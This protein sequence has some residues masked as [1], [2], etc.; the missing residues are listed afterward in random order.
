M[1]GK[2]KALQDCKEKLA[3]DSKARNQAPTG[4][5]STPTRSSSTREKNVARD[6]SPLRIANVMT[7]A[8]MSMILLVFPLSVRES[9][10]DRFAGDR[11]TLTSARAGT[12]LDH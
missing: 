2:K 5:H 10:L 9:S 12:I 3:K 4:R 1:E 8:P 11:D 7:L 6:R